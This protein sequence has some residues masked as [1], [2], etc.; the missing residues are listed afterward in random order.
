MIAQ[1]LQVAESN[2]YRYIKDFKDKG[3][4]QHEAR[5][6]SS[7]KLSE[8]QTQELSSHLQDK[9]Y[10]YVKEKDIVTY[11]FKT[12]GIKYSIDGMR[13]WLIHHGFRYK[14]PA[15][16]P[17]KMDPKQQEAFQESIKT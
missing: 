15:T 14:K 8:A 13:C 9:T 5:G 6:G 4:I 12:Y 3:K 1:V 17:G 7:S 11:V 10:L 2:V 16:V